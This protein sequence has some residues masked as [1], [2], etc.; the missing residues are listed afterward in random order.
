MWDESTESYSGSLE[1]CTSCE[2]L[3]ERQPTAREQMY[4]QNTLR[5]QDGRVPAVVER[6][7]EQ[8]ELAAAA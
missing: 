1:I 3:I 5:W 2:T 7:D 6:I 8:I 4:E